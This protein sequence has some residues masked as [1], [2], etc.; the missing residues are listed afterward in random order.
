M[1]S[2]I[3]DAIALHVSWSG[4]DGFFQCRGHIRR[5][6]MCNNIA[7]KVLDKTYDTPSTKVARSYRRTGQ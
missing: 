3:G 6:R 2:Q 7:V 5:K 4:R 1:I